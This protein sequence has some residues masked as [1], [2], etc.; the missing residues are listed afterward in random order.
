MHCELGHNSS[1][2]P[3]TSPIVLAVEGLCLAGK[4]TLVNA[5]TT[6]HPAT[7]AAPDYADLAPL[8]PWPPHHDTDVHAALRHFLRLEQQRART[9][10]HPSQVVVL[11]RSPLTLIAHEYGMVRLGIP[12]APDLAADLFADSAEHSQILTPDAYIHVRAPAAVRAARRAQRGPVPGHL[13]DR[14]VEAGIAAATRAYLDQVPP[15][16]RLLLDGTANTRHLLHHV[17]QF[18]AALP[19]HGQQPPPSWRI[20]AP[21]AH[22][23]ATELRTAS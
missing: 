19:P 6:Q 18:I 2:T 23:Q 15:Q 16:R 11:D 10:R 14:S 22:P 8:P 7:T 13:V 4:T 5:L 17:G 20:L 9:A 3:A 21:T 1:H 12:A